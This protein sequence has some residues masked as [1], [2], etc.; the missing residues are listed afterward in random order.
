ME[1]VEK[2]MWSQVPEGIPTPEGSILTLEEARRRFAEAEYDLVIALPCSGDAPRGR[3]TESPATT[4]VVLW[5]G[6]EEPV[7]SRELGDTVSL[8][9]DGFEHPAIGVLANASPEESAGRW[10]PLLLRAGR[11]RSA[12]TP[13]EWLRRRKSER[14]DARADPSRAALMGRL[15]EAAVGSPQEDLVA[16]LAL[17]YASQERSSQFETLEE[18]TEL[19]DAC[20]SRLRSAALAGTPDPFL[21][22]TWE[23]LARILARKR[24]IEKVY[25][26]VQPVAEKHHPWPALEIVLAQA[27]LESL[28]PEDAV[29]R[30]RALASISPP[31]FETQDLLGRAHCALNQPNEALEAWKGALDLPSDDWVS[32]KRVTLAVARTGDPAGIK[33]A[34]RLFIENPDDRVLRSFLEQPLGSGPPGDPCSN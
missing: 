4:T 34:Q 3:A 33:A 29:R 26:F 12:P 30:L 1:R 13:L 17:F 32:R 15:A 31:T 28:A 20:L 6:I 21:R 24:W 8:T 22:R 7:V 14:G 5:I 9:M 16:G 18:R 10:A 23:S 19:P 25:A 27:D 11:A 2:A